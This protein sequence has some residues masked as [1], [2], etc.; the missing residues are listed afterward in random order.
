MTSIRSKLSAACAATDR[1]HSGP[2]ELAHHAMN[3]LPR[4]AAIAVGSAILLAIS[5]AGWLAF[6]TPPVENL[7][8]SPELIG[9]S[10][11]EGQRLVATAESKADLAQLQPHLVPQARR[12]FCGPAT[13][14]AVVNASLEPRPPATQTSL[15]NAAA[16]AVKSELALS[17][18]GLTLE[19]LA[20]FI[21]AQGLQVQVVHASSEGLAAFRDTASRTLG[22]PSTFLITN[23]DRR[24]LKQSGAGHISPVGAF[25]SKTDRVLILDVA[26]Q[27]Y[28][29]TWVPV[30]ALWAAMNT[31]DSDSGQTRG[32]LL[33]T[34]GRPARGDSSQ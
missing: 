14:A 31:I 19:E 11:A 7:P 17:F 24:V 2:R 26:T 34:A 27:K 10:S 5:I 20:A 4:N 9:I 33:V 22:E 12:A 13:T 30:S 18:S 15:F 3:R 23:Y 1:A 32:Y 29:Y 16:S 21:R 8:L 6:S 25:D 28:P